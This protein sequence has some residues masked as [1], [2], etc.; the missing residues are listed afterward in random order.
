MRRQTF[1]IILVALPLLAGAATGVSRQQPDNLAFVDL[2]A[3]QRVVDQASAALTAVFNY[4]YRTLDASL[5]A[6]K[7]KGTEDYAAR[8]AEDLNKLRATAT[9]QKQTI[10]TKVVG[11]GVHDLRAQTAALVV[12]LDQTTTRGDQNRSTTAGLTAVVDLTLAG[13]E[14]KLDHVALT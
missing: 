4:D 11:V 1:A 13:G 3:T 14:W 7:Q 12:F 5:T 9:K 8:H 6:A 2:A 10:A